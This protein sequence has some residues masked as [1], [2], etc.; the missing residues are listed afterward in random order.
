MQIGIDSFA[1]AISDPATGLMLSPVERMRHLLKEIE[2][3][4]QVGLDVFGIGE[5][6]PGG[7]PRFSS[8]CDPLRCRR[9]HGKYPPHQRSNGSQC[10]RPR[11]RFSGVRDSANSS[12]CHKSENMWLRLTRSQ[13][14]RRR[15]TANPNVSPSLSVGLSPHFP[16]VD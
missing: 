7:V 1:A 15:L 11:S 16:F 3:A 14:A 12:L 5:H 4:D 2:L 9:A 6:H 10:L 8:R 13:P